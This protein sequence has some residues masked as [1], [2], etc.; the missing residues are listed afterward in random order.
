L[1]QPLVEVGPAFVADPQTLE[2]VEPC[3]GPLDNPAGATEPGTVCDA[4]AGDEW[5]DATLP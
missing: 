3:E 1:E 2:L 5:L 4:A